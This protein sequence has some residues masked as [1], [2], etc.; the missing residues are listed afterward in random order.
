MS[1]GLI[2]TSTFDMLLPTDWKEIKDIE[3]TKILSNKK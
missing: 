2:I 1:R 3:V